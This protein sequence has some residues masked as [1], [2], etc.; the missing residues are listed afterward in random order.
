MTIARAD[1]TQTIRP[2]DDVNYKLVV[3]NNGPVQASGVTVRVD[4]PTA[5]RY[6]ST[7]SIDST[8]ATTRTQPSDPPVD[9]ADPQWGQWSMGPPGINADGTPAHSKLFITLDVRAAGGPADYTITPHVFSDSSDEVVGAALKVHLAAASDLNLAIAADQ[10]QARRGDVVRY[11]LT[12][13][14]RG[15]GVAKAVG[16]M[17]TLPDGII[18]D[19]TEHLDGNFSR[20]NPIDPISG[21]LIVYY[22]GW[23][24]PAASAARPGALTV[25]FS[26]KVLPT[27][28]AGTYPVTAQLTDGDGTLVQINDTAPV[29][30][31][32]P[33]PSPSPAPSA[34]AGTH[35]ATPPP[36]PTPTPKHD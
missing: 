16:I 2:G 11:R 29:T 19:K 18:F 7:P 5:F 8:G 12:L 9:S 22:G 28:V 24:L 32:A 4:L 13:I 25:V 15:S 17:V 14:N 33:T 6:K 21:A 23:V 10:L 1:P 3:S 20:A 30:I 36:T 26:A 27:A 31:L 34:T 35:P